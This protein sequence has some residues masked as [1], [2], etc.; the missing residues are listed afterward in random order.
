MKVLYDKDCDVITVSGNGTVF[1]LAAP[2]EDGTYS[3]VP[4]TLGFVAK[5]GVHADA[6]GTITIF[7]GGPYDKPHGPSP[8]DLE[9]W[10]DEQIPTPEPSLIKRTY[11]KRTK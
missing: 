8:S 9:G 4:M 6:V 5:E 3:I 11:N 10:P 1:H 7:R 2:P